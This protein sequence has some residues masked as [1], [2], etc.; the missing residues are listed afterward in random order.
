M[1]PRDGAAP[2]AR[3]ARGSTLGPMRPSLCALALSLSLSACGPELVSP[4]AEALDAPAPDAVTPD[5]PAPD[6]PLSDAPAPSGTTWCSRGEP[7]RGASVPEGFCIRHFAS[8]RSPRTMTFA[9]DGALFVGAPR[10]FAPGGS[11][12]G[13]GAVLLFTDD[14]RDGSGEPHVF[15]SSRLV[16]GMPY[17]GI[18]DVHGV[19]FGEGYLY[20]TTLASIYRVPYTPGQLEADAARMEDLSMPE[21]YGSRS[22]THGLARSV[23]GALYTSGGMPGR[24]CGGAPTGAIFR[25]GANTLS[26]QADGFRNPMYMR[27]HPREELC[28][29]AELGED[30]QTGAREKLVRIRPETNYGYPC[31][32]AR[33]VTPSGAAGCGDVTQEEQSFTIGDTPFGLDWERGSWPAP[34]RDALFIAMHGSFYTSPA[35]LGA[36]VRYW[37]TDPSTHLPTGEWRHF[38]QGVGAGMQINRP[39]DVAFSPDGR[40]FISDDIGNDIYWVA[41]TDL[42]VA[43]R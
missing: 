19:A 24:A 37:P 23:G 33:G 8:I 28:L 27:C 17:R 4:D 31:C 34:F 26:V 40:M 5:V 43:G 21:S 36:G 41:P 11:N 2:A 35:W 12:G 6:A 3:V 13:P 7:V 9:P 29:A 38:V 39:S 1:V 10:T 20:F 18:P 25:A 15:A 16:H 14:D 42:A 22:W 32:Y 30:L